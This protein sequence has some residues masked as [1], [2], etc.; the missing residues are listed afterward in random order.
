[1]NWTLSAISYVYFSLV[2]VCYM[3]GYWTPLHFNI[4][5]FLS[6]VDVIKSAAYPIVPALIG[7]FIWVAMDTVNS[8]PLQRVEKDDNKTTKTLFYMMF[9]FLAILFLINLYHVVIFLY[10]TVVSE[11]ER[12]LAFALPIVSILSTIFF[13]NKPPFLLEHSRYIR[14]F[15]IIFMCALPTI[16]FH[17]GDI[18]ISQTLLGTKGYYSLVKS[19]KNCSLG[20]SEQYIYLG[21]YSSTLFFVNKSTKDLCLEREGGANLKYVSTKTE[22]PKLKNSP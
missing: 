6:P 1:M 9:A 2:G 16:A 11:P 15:V 22:E 3:L 5:D 4:L 10:L 19:S 7:S 12:R 14:H 17:Q 21:F 8:Q 20:E 13:L 18:N